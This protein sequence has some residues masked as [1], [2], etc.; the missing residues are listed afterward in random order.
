[1]T[2]WGQSGPLA[3][4]PGHDI[5]YI[6][7]AGVLHGV[8]RKETTPTPPSNLVGDFGGGGL[9]LAFGVMCALFERASSGRGQVVDAAM[10]DGAALLSTFQHGWLEGGQWIDERGV[11]ILDGA[12]PY[13]DTYETSDG[14]YIAVGAVEPKF[15]AAFLER[16]AVDVDP[17][18]QDDRSTWDET[19]AKIGSAILQRR[20]DEWCEIFH[21]SESCV[22][23]VLGM[24]EAP[25]H[26]HNQARRTFVDVDGYLQPAPAPRFSRTPAGRPAPPPDH[27]RTP[28]PLTDW[29]VP[30][31]Y[32]DA[33]IVAGAL[34]T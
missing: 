20:R 2:G 22:T 24:R 34:A 31:E 28:A 17:A 8:G 30:N 18:S 5:N 11:N 33:A 26:P 21:E 32:I 3:P 4:T 6:A 25:H 12:A 14:L 23:P 15:Y 13:Y 9:L 16:L 27:R 7:L 19:R 1:M 29:E 10:V